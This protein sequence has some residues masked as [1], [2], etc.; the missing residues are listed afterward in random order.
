MKTLVLFPHQLYFK[1]PNSVD[2]QTPIYLIEEFLFFKQYPFHKQKLVFHRA[3]MKAYEA[4]LKNLGFSVQ[5]IDAHEQISDARNLV[6][7]LQEQ[8]ITELICFEP[9][10]FWLKKRLVI[11]AEEQG[12]ILDFHPNQLFIN[13]IEDLVLYNKEHKRLFQTDFYIHQRKKRGILLDDFGGPLGG[14]WSFDADNRKKYPAKKMAPPLPIANKTSFH[15]EALDYVNEYFSANLG[16]LQSIVGY[17][18]TPADANLWLKQFFE[19]RFHEFGEYEDAIVSGESFL[20]HS[21]LTP[22]LNVGML[23]PIDVIHAAIDFAHENGVEMNSLEGFV[24]QILGWREFVRYVYHFHSV[25]Q[26]TSNFWQF[27]RKIPES[28]YDGTTGIRPVDDAIKKLNKTAYNHHIERL[29]VLSNFMLLC[30]FDPDEVYQW[31]M[32]MYIDAYDWV[33]VPNVY[34][35]AQFA[36]GGKMVTKP[37]ISGS[38]YIFKMSDYKK[39]EPWADVWDALFWRFMSVHRD[40]FKK[41][42]RL[43]MLINTFDKWEP[44]KRNAY[45][46]RAEE[47]LRGLNK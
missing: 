15:K 13:T 44:E 31:F 18:V 26:R 10:D 8:G 21:I 25:E 11:G 16:D 30:E 37:Y 6:P 45:F 27:K 2:T 19:Q 35:M 5:Y 43:S 24:R 36:D 38:N 34:G 22:M 1:F 40:F 47:F 29:M 39:G 17:P 20:N 42:P 41:N 4:Y 3:S 33:M 12:I 14:K 7:H 28:F 46:D 9:D 32:E 23:K